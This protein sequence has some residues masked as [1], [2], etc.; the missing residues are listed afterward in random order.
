MSKFQG[1]NFLAL[2]L[3]QNLHFYVR[4]MSFMAKL[5]VLWNYSSELVPNFQWNFKK[6]A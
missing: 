6:L 2:R 4:E 5:V 3:S 1:Y